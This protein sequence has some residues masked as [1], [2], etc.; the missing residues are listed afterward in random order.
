ML[1]GG[2]WGSKEVV[3]GSERQMRLEES[4]D[5]TRL[6]LPSELANLLLSFFLWHTQ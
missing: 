1:G 6:V 4:K 5:T 3:H 2:E